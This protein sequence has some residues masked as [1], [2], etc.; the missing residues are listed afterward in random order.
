MG[1]RCDVYIKFGGRISRAAAEALVTV[2]KDEHYRSD[3]QDEPEIGN[4]DESFLSEEVN[5]A[6]IDA[7]IAVC[8]EHHIDYDMWHS[9]GGGYGEGC[10]RFMDGVTHQCANSDD[11]P[12]VSLRSLLDVETLASGMGDLIK[13]A[14]FMCGDFPNLVIEE[15]VDA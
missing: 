6:N 1:D 3:D 14:R 2:L 7:I 13:L 11:G 15:T 4:L 8:H 9:A 10:E 5:Y 12:L